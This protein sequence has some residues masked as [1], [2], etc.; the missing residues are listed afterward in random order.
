MSSTP[1]WKVTQNHR[2]ELVSTHRSQRSIDLLIK[3]IYM[4]LYI[5]AP[6]V[7]GEVRSPGN[8]AIDNCESP[9]GRQQ[10]NPGPQ[11]EQLFISLAPQDFFF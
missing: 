8:R 7:C 9:C 3:N 5:Y 1:R 11:Q 6:C 2:P 4:R 10:W